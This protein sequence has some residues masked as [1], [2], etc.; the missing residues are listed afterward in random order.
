MRNNIVAFRLRTKQFDGEPHTGG[1]SLKTVF[2]GTK[3]YDVPVR[4]D[5]IL[6]VAPARVYS[7]LNDHDIEQLIG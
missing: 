1:F 6:M 3:H 5:E 7:S 4:Q 2:S